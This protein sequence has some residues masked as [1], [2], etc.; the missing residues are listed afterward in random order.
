MLVLLFLVN[1]IL[2]AQNPGTAYCGPYNTSEPI[3]LNDIHDTTITGLEI[4]NPDGH[5]IR[6][7]NCTNITIE[8]CFLRDASGNGVNVENS[9]NIT[10]TN[11]SMESIATGVYVQGQ[12][13]QIQ[14]L[15][16]T[17]V[18]VNGP[19]PRG[20]LTQFNGVSGENNKINYNVAENFLGESYPEDIINVYKSNGTADS[21]IEIKGNWI[22]GG[23]PSSSGGGILVGDNG[24]SYTTVEDNILVNPGQYGLAIAGGENMKLLNNTVF[25]EQ[26][27]FNNVGLY[28]WNQ[29]DPACGNHTVSGNSVN[30]TKADGTKNNA[31]NGN[32][33]GEIIG[34][35]DNEWG[36][37]IDA[38][39]LPEVIDRCAIDVRAE[40]LIAHYEFN[41]NMLDSTDNELHGTTNTNV[42]FTTN[43]TAEFNGT[44]S[45]I[46]IPENDLLSPQNFTF[47][48]WI[49]PN[50]NNTGTRAIVKS[51]KG[52][53][54]YSGWRL[55]TSE[56][57]LSGLIVS[58]DSEIPFEELEDGDTT[59]IYANTS[60]PGIKT[61]EWNFIV[62]TYDGAYMKVYIDDGS[63]ATTEY[64]GEIYYDQASNSSFMSF[65]H[66]NGEQY[67][68]GEIG[69]V[70]L[71][72]TAFSDTVVAD[73]YNQEKR[74]YIE[75][76][77][78]TA[79]ISNTIKTLIYPNP[80][81]DFIYIKA[82]DFRGNK[83]IEIMNL[84]GKI[85]L[86]KELG[87]SISK[88]NISEIKSGFY[89]SK[90]KDPEGNIQI[91][92]IVV[93]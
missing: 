2:C 71:Y 5:C 54:Y 47:T 34:W 91:E 87:N 13:S 81:R 59:R 64:V 15:Y 17:C 52:S 76:T 80:S 49:K 50:A 20:Q 60:N 48:A 66:T 8:N 79:A 53:G 19:F 33:C 63:P 44:D 30:Y 1:F 84:T 12:S 37:D 35:D 62:L 85:L 57:A 7:N 77:L 43:S 58:G 22:R 36:A 55:V 11:C 67:F 78:S 90:I 24:G 3:V 16:N 61:D 92:K 41:N 18:N 68:S 45:T 21:P 42:S 29:Y 26:K 40:N 14:V 9:S 27:D 65:G 88:V 89:L 74:L 83:S 72:N 51:A 23:G 25:A 31:W 69:N 38:S 39:I 28:V 82:P 70:K 32:N 46:R 93:E 56:S 6:L 73:F 75:N 10:V 86:H 4:T